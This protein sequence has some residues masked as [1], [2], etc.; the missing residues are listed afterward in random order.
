[1]KT[2]PEAL[3]FPRALALGGDGRLL[4]GEWLGRVWSLSRTMHDAVL[5]RPDTST[6]AASAVRAA[7]EVEETARSRLAPALFTLLKV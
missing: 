2:P 6:A 1:L 3:R 5:L 7:L 4:V